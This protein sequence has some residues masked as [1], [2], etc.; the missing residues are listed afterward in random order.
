MTRLKF[1]DAHHHLWDLSRLTYPWLEAKGSKRFFGQPDPIRKNYLPQDYFNDH[2]GQVNSSIHIQVGCIPEHN[3]RET[4]LI[5]SFVDHGAPIS[6][7]IPSVDMRSDDLVEQ[8]DLQQAFPLV[9]GVRH[10]IGK[11]ASENHQLPVFKGSDW[12]E[13]WRLLA[14]RKLTFDLQLTEEQ[15]EDVYN[16]LCNVPELNVVICHLAS[17]WDQSKEGFLRWQ[18]AMKKFAKLPNCS[19]KISGFSMFNH[20]MI[21]EKFA[22]YI[23]AAIDIFGPHRC[24]FGSNFPVDKLYIS[25][26]N[27]FKIWQK[28]LACYNQEESKQL[29]AGSA[30]NF[31][32]L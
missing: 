16:T 26:T 23:H 20:G 6:A 25:Y 12:I 4:Q 19:M 8:L 31:Y 22:D 9:K 5:S 32:Q 17:P 24:M 30:A 10:M 27:L 13:A 1:I 3:I 7:I 21:E 11:S 18:L 28:I 14:K 15:Y 29:T 2:Q